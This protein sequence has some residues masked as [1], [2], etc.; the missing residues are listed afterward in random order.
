MTERGVVPGKQAGRLRA[1]LGRYAPL[2]AAGLAQAKK[3]DVARRVWERDVTLWPGVTEAGLGWL[4]APGR[5]AGQLASLRLFADGVRAAGFE[6]AL[7]LGVG[8]PYLALELVRTTFGVNEGYLTLSALGSTDADAVTARARRLDGRTLLIVS[9]KTGGAAETRALL[10]FFYNRVADEVGAAAGARFVAVCDPGDPLAALAR[11]L[12]FRALFLNDPGV[13]G[14]YAAL[15][16]CGLLPAALAGADV[17][18]LQAQARAGA[19]ACRAEGA[20][21][22]NAGVW[23]GTVL[24]VLAGAGRDKVTFVLPEGLSGLGTWLERLLAEA[25]GKG[26]TGVVPVAGEPLGAPEVYGDDRVFVRISLGN[27]SSENTNPGNTGPKHDAPRENA[28][29]R[30]E[31][32]GHPVVRVG[33]ESPYDALGQLFVW[34]FGA[35]VA[36]YHLGANPFARPG[37]ARADAHT[38]A[39]I[40]RYGATRTLPDEAAAASA[41]TLLAFLA[42]AKAGDY[43]ALHAYLPLSREVAA[44]LGRFRAAL[45]DRLK[46]PVTCAFGPHDLRGAGGPREGGNVGHVVQL[47]SEPQRNA[48]I[49]DEAGEAASSLSFYVLKKAQA[50]GDKRALEEAGRRVTLFNLGQRVVAGL[51]ALSRTS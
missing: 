20:P 33:L 22:D 39:L 19:A 21:E 25:T 49:P 40:A 38:R 7:L 3:D 12:R 9:D 14:C 30:L 16:L 29:G 31:A 28:L 36:A 42:E 37:A 1:A 18:A 11:R 45:R 10:T 2:V 50:L 46:L 13:P 44:A 41:E 48:P 4:D 15:S 24:G 6:R 35:A 27:T 8:A 26:G 47:L 17:S 43:V 34:Q 32:A 5:T 23:L 51:S